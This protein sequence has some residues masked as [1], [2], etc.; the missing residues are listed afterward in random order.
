MLGVVD[1]SSVHQIE[2]LVRSPASDIYRGGEIGKRSY[3]RHTLQCPEQV[4]LHYSRD[5][6]DFLRAHFQNGDRLVEHSLCNAAGISG[7]NDFANS[8]S[9]FREI[10]LQHAGVISIKQEFDSSRIIAHVSN[11]ESIF[12]GGNVGD[13]EK[14]IV[15][16][17]TAEPV[18]FQVDVSPYEG[19]ACRFVIDEPL[20]RRVS[21]NHRAFRSRCDLR[22]SRRK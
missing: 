7:Y 14:T 1:F 19:F 3:A 13:C 16:G 21:G 10:N 15:V 9:G 22:L 5:R 8:V 20:Y 11:D 18:V 17:R 12:T 6:I 2:I 4:R